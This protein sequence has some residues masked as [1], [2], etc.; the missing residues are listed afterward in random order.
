[1][2]CYAEKILAVQATFVTG[3]QVA[4]LTRFTVYEFG[5]AFLYV[6]VFGSVFLLSAA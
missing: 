2:R 5:S 6:E 4:G 3:A 1:M